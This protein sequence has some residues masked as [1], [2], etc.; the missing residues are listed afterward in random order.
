[1]IFSIDCV[2]WQEVFGAGRDTLMPFLWNVVAREG[3]LFGNRALGS[4]MR[5]TNRLNFSYPG[6]QE[7][8]AGYPDPR[9]DNNHFGPNPNVTVLEFLNRQPA[10]AGRVA[11]FVNWKVIDQIFARRGA[12]FPVRAGGER[13]EEVMP[14]EEVHRLV[15][16]H[17][18]EQKPRVLFIGFGEADGEAHAGRLDRYL[19]AI[20]DA[21]RFIGELWKTLQADEAY[22]A[23]TT[24]IITTDHGRGRGDNWRSHGWRTRGS[25]ETW[26]A[27]IGPGT[28]ALGERSNTSTTTSQVAATIAAAL[29]YDY[30]AFAKRAARPIPSR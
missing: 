22:R 10:L 7:M 20:R 24:L 2:R 8:L 28:P 18:A 26:L 25:G 16:R 11:A 5:V 12:D 14:D 30:R 13:G 27:I 3:Q 17:I 1:M 19:A 21:D 15:M 29:G 4:N 6:Y 23:K 9:I